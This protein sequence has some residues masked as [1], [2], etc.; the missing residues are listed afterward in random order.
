MWRAPTEND[1]AAH[2]SQKE[3]DAFR[4][5][6]PAESGYDPVAHVLTNAAGLVRAHIRAGKRGR[7]DPREGTVP[8]GLMG[9]LLDYAAYD[10]LKRLP[11]DVNEDR[12]RAREQAVQ[13]MKD[14]AVG[15]LV[16]EPYGSE[17]DDSGYPTFRQVRGLMD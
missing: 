14:L 2:L 4:A 10:V 8:E 16:P 3:V 12:R 5:S 1:L 7:L 9:P 13:M 15:Q 17:C 6:V 11:V